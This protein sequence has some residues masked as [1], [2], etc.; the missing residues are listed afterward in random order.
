MLDGAR[1]RPWTGCCLP[2]R[3]RSQEP[4][5]WAERRLRGSVTCPMPRCGSSP[6]STGRSP[7]IQVGARH[8]AR[9][10]IVPHGRRRDG[11]LARVCADRLNCCDARESASRLSRFLP[12]R[13]SHFATTFSPPGAES[14]RG[15]VSRSTT[16]HRSSRWS[17]TPRRAATRSWGSCTH[18]TDKGEREVALRPE[19]TPT[20]ARMV[21]ARAQ[22]L[23]KPI[24]WFSIPQLFRYERQQRGRLREHFQLNM[25]II[26][27]AGPGGRRRGDGG[28][29]RHHAGVRARSPR[30]CGCGCRIAG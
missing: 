14:P 15:T 18:F 9:D 6:T 12:R 13:H 11:A 3:P 1:I 27:E 26:G 16:G 8:G 7:T 21:G 5:R 10:R 2:W 17:S 19:M 22:A 4:Q 25:D 28:R 29:D 20:L 24:R 30:K 23:K